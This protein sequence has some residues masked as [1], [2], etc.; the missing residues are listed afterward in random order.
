LTGNSGRQRHFFALAGAKVPLSCWF[1]RVAIAQR[2]AD[3]GI[4]RSHA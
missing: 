4:C 2:M 3:F 1:R